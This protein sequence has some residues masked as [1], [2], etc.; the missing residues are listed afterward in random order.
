MPEKCKKLSATL[1]PKEWA[2]KL[3]SRI[4]DRLRNRLLVKVVHN[5]AASYQQ[6]PLE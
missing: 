1:S 6:G 2:K 4:A 3:G 5:A